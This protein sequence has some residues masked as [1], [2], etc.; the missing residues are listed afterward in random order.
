MLTETDIHYIVGLL[1]LIASPENVQIE[2]GSMVYDNAAEKARDVDVTITFVD[3]KGNPTVLKG[4]EVKKHGRPLDVTHVEQL[5][6]K[7]NDMKCITHRAIV[8][9]SGYTKPAI[10][11]AVSH[12]L[13]L[14]LFTNWENTSKGFEHF[15]GY[16][17]DHMCERDLKLIGEPVI[18]FNLGDKI[19]KED[20][21]NL[22][23]NPEILFGEDK[24]KTEVPD[25]IHL[26]N[27]IMANVKKAVIERYPPPLI[28]DK[29][30]TKYFS[31]NINISDN[32]YLIT[33]SGKLIIK[34]ARVSVNVQWVETKK[35]LQFKILKKLGDDNPFAGCAITEIS[36]GNLIGLTVSNS[37]RSIKL[38]NI[39]ISDR[40]K[41]K[42]LK[43]RIK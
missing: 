13:D 29:N 42:I 30:E 21:K 12:G 34:Q 36:I 1:Y 19:L 20:I 11:K 41:D 25:L 10:K 33:P 39:P 28:I 8:S 9:A 40:N 16:I 35:E 2:M 27:N 14:Y 18:E 24:K 15:G 3:N 31:I 17:S 5:A 37:N 22:G 32:P 23:N 38:I 43:H 7:L 26:I 6:A 4:I